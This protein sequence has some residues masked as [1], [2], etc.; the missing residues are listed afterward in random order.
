MKL[1]LDTHIIL[2]ALDDNPKLSSQARKL[3]VDAG[4]DIYYSSASIWETTIKYMAK[5][6]KI[7]I[8][9]SQ[10]SDLCKEMGYRMLPIADNHIKMLETLVYHDQGQVHNDPFDRIMIAQA[11]ADGLKFITH[12]S[13]IPLYEESCIIA[14]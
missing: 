2:W 12:D 8:S 11:K 1:L 13:K 3:I 5:P 6:D 14:V 9:G 7:H 10:L 4:N